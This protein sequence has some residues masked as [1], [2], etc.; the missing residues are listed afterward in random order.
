MQT[1][2]SAYYLLCVKHI[3]YELKLSNLQLLYLYNLVQPPVLSPVLIAAPSSAF[4]LRMLNYFEFG[5]LFLSSL[6][7]ALVLSHS[8]YENTAVSDT[9][10][11]AVSA[12]L[13]DVA[14]FMISILFIDNSNDRLCDIVCDAIIARFSKRN[15]MQAAKCK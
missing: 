9:V 12:Q 8:V 4:I 1:F 15:V 2:F 10:L 13:K 11:C 3:Q 7:F 5:S 6:S 14:L